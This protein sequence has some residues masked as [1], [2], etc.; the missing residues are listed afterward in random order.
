M[1]QLTSLTDMRSEP[2]WLGQVRASPSVSGTD[3]ADMRGRTMTIR[4]VSSIIRLI[5]CSRLHA[6]DY[7]R[8]GPPEITP[9]DTAL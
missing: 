3:G 6:L 4:C 8:A 9:R 5:S 7:N 1:L 2:G